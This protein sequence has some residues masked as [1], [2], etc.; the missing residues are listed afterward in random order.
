MSKRSVE[1]DVS[2]LNAEWILSRWAFLTDQ[3]FQ[4]RSHSLISHDFHLAFRIQNSALLLTSPLPAAPAAG[5]ATRPK[6]GELSIPAA[7]PVAFV[8]APRAG[9]SPAAGRA[10]SKSREAATTMPWPAPPA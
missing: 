6:S 8:P 10:G 3:L 1:P 4:H 5:R 9:E 7:A 2:G